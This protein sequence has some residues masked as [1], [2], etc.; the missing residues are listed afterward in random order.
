MPPRPAPKVPF[1]P[2]DRTLVTCDKDFA[3]HLGVS[4]RQ[5]IRWRQTGVSIPRAEDICDHFGVHP[6][7]V[8]GAAWFETVVPA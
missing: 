4:R 7:E 5:I 1:G 3:D 6:A 2:I 8:W